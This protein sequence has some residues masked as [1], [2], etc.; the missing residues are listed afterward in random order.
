MQMLLREV[1][2]FEPNLNWIEEEEPS[3]SV[4]RS[5]LSASDA[6]LEDAPSVLGAGQHSTNVEE[7]KWKLWKNV[8][9]RILETQEAPM[10]VI[11]FEK[12]VAAGAIPRS[13]QNMTRDVEVAGIVVFVS[14]R[15]FDPMNGRPDDPGGPIKHGLIVRG[16]RTLMEQADP[17]TAARFTIW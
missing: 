6:F 2:A 13:D 5:H 8:E 14:H 3:I 1:E 15:W 16:V 17:L 10:R 4:R 7:F 9:K 12:F 11:E